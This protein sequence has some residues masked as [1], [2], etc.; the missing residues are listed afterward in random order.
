MAFDTGNIPCQFG[1]I[2]KSR[3]ERAPR[4]TA[5]KA[6][7]TGIHPIKYLRRLTGLIAAVLILAAAAH[8]AEAG[9]A[10]FQPLQKRLVADG[11]SAQRIQH[12]YQKPQAAFDTRSVSLFFVHSEA[13]LN[14]DQFATADAVGR[15]RDYLGTHEK[16]LAAAE[17]DYGVDREIIAAILLVET[18]L[19]TMTGASNIFNA[20]STMAALT[21]P[22]ARKVLWR[23]L[24]TGRRLS[25]KAFEKKADKKSKWAYDE[26]K[27]LIRYADREGIDPTTLTGSYAGAMG[28]SQ[29]MPSNA[30]RLGIDG[31]GD[32]RVD[33]FAHEDAIASVGNYLRHHGW[34]RGMDNKKAYKVIS[35]LQL[36]FLLCSHHF[37]NRPETQ[38]LTMDID[39]A[40]K[41][42]G[43]CIPFF[44]ATVWAMVDAAQRDFGTLGAKLL[45]IAVAA[46][47]FVGF[48][49]YFVL[50]A[51]R[52][53]K[54]G[55]A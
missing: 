29:F 22:D 18:Q 35:A 5:P 40:L 9:K 47:P 24:P 13:R 36:Q 10:F 15:A 20:L 17:N 49:I 32:G 48:I 23:A 52:G 31:N 43:I 19:G 55:Q 14:Y 4:P 46:V 21:D 33:L 50:G 25:R 45:W 53:K 41:F 51:R 12:L 3:A 1:A 11:F 8:G 26:L 37:E 27:A 42:I 44:L 7:M 6:P 34:A 2:K 30:L 54:P 38:K 16:S 39:T 28:I